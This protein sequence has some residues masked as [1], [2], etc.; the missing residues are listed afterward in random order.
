MF[1]Y[2]ITFLIFVADM[3]FG[4]FDKSRWFFCKKNENTILINMTL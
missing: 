2:K 3:P 1:L 4:M